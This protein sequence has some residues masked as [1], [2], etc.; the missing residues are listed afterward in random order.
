MV[1]FRILSVAVG[2]AILLFLIQCHWISRIGYLGFHLDLLLP[3]ALQVAL[4]M[5]LAFALCWCL[6]WGF[7]M[8]T[9]T[10]RLWGLHV[11][12]YLLVLVLVYVASARF[13]LRNRLYRC[14]CVAICALIEA[15]VIGV[16]SVIASAAPPYDP[17]IWVPLLVRTAGIVVVTPVIGYPFEKYVE[18]FRST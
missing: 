1:W 3:L 12:T 17:T 11:G 14:V 6:G 9:F 13:E 18:Q 16:Y 4:E 7:V 8:D 10:G 2:Y 15:I 5:P